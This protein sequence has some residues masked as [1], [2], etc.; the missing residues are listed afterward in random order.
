MS[1]ATLSILDLVPVTEG[2][3]V[4]GAIERSMRG[5]EVADEL[6]YER[7]WFAEHHN[8]QT[9]ASSATVLLMDQALSRSKRIRVGSGGIM[10]PNHSPLVVAEQFG[11]LVNMHGSRVDLGLG[12]APGTDPITAQMLHRTSA[13]P[14]V[15]AN[16]I[17]QM[18]QWFS[19]E[20]QI[21]QAPIKA[22]VARGTNVPMW[23]LGSTVNGASIAA[24]L[25]LPFAVASHF[26]PEQ[27]DAAI[28][29][30]RDQFTTESL[31]AQIDEPRVMVGVNVCVAET[32]EEAELLFSTHQKVFLGIRSANREL[33]KPP[34]D[35]SAETDEFG[36][37]FVNGALQVRAV[38]SPTTV[39]EK[40]AALQERTGA[41][42]FITTTY[43]YDDNAWFKHLRLLADA[44]GI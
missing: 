41:D 29:T 11:T 15:F 32:D 12:R 8:T 5:V 10:L 18:Q 25:G 28:A 26:A 4:A 6:G 39:A 19:P 23:V 21:S 20:G 9:L 24:Q 3:T 7:Y 27:L 40:L 2:S 13:D 22:G 17:F 14:Q 16:A 33:L 38:G 36:R 34:S 43:I 42:E 1:R 31:T 44:W 37:S 30:Y 35:F